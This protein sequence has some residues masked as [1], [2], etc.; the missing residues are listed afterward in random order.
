MPISRW[1]MT[2]VIALVSAL[3]AFAAV[4]LAPLVSLYNEKKKIAAQ[5]V[6][7][8][9]QLWINALRDDLAHFVTEIRHIAA[10]LAANAITE[11]EAIAR[12]GAMTICEERIKL[13]LNPAE[14]EHNELVRL[15]GAASTRL[16]GAI[17]KRQSMAQE[18]DT[19]ADRIVEEA[20]RILK[21]E[22]N[23]VKKGE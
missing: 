13:R 16:Q 6:S 11:K 22:W 4:V 15:M 20:Q 9:R 18:L 14:T 12:Y 23:R 2:E 7:S 5:V 21:S 10:A 1:A 3:T 17:N 8:N 19:A